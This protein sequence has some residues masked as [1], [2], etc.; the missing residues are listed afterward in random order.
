[1]AACLVGYRPSVV[2]HEAPAAVNGTPS[3]N[4]RVVP[5]TGTRDSNAPRLPT[6]ATFTG[7]LGTFAPR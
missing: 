1:M 3:V 4:V 7:S 6:N 5:L 2:T